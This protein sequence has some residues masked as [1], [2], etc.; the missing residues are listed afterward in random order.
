MVPTPEFACLLMRDGR[1]YI[2]KGERTACTADRLGGVQCHYV[3]AP[4]VYPFA[5]QE[6]GRE[7][8]AA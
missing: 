3:T 8:C 5:G 4:R 2:A 1:G 7:Q 6:E